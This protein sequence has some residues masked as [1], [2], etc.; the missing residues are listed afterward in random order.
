MAYR[1]GEA[2]QRPGAGTTFT[3]STHAMEDATRTLRASAVLV[4]M[5]EVRQDINPQLLAKALE[6]DLNIPWDQMHVSKHHPEDFLVRFGHARHRDIAVDAGV[7]TCQ[8]VAPTLSPW[9]PTTRGH[10]RISRFYCRLAIEGI[11]IQA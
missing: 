10:Q 9:S 1:P 2:S 7:A 5:S 4:T 8:G 11:P 6:R 3:I